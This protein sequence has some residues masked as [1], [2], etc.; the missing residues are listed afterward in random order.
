MSRSPLILLLVVALPCAAQDTIWRVVPGIRFGPVTSASDVRRLRAAVGPANVS[1]AALDVVEGFTDPGVILFAHDSTRRAYVYWRDTATRATPRGV[2]LRDRGSRW[3]LPVDVHVGSS[4]SD[5][6]ALNGKPFTLAGF[7]WDY[8]GRAGG[9]EGG[10]LSTLLGRG[11]SLQVSFDATC[12]EKLPRPEW[13]S[14][15]GDKLLWSS[16]RIVRAACAT[17]TEVFL[18]FDP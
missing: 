13:E 18:A 11:M 17:V 9:W 2:A 10:R 15:V 6:E 16:D 8:G 12:L 4:I 1:E 3:R 14:I 5:V 7:A